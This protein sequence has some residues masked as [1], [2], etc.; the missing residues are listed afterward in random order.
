VLARDARAD[1]TFVYAVKS[2]G[3]Y[4]RPSCPSR[5]PGRA[6]AVFFKRTEDARKAGFRACRRCHPDQPGRSDER[7]FVDRVRRR[8]EEMV[9]GGGTPTLAALSAETGLSPFHLQRRFKSL[10]GV[11]PKR[12]AQ[13]LRLEKF[14]S[15]LGKGSDVTGALYEAGYGSSSRLYEN[16]G[17]RMGM[18]PAAY[19]RGGQNMD[20]R[21]DVM[22]TEK[23]R[24]LVAATPRGVCAVDV[25][26]TDAQLEERLRRC[27][28]RARVRRERGCFSRE[29]AAVSGLLS[30]R[31]EKV[32]L[33]LDLQGTAFQCRV[34]A[35]LS[36]I[37][38]G[39]TRT[40]T[41]VA[42]ALG[43]EKAARAVANACAG[44]RVP[45]VIPCHRVIRKGGELGG[46]R[47]GLDRKKAL[48][49]AEASGRGG[50]K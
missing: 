49:A 3:I 8:I 18:T 50:V 33:P 12:Y 26:A 38:Y 1:N 48:L 41:D 24:L 11:T 16:I 7:R 32:S 21:Y 19:G 28:P 22:S 31:P 20:I 36:R 30:G 6:Q 47:L 5:R 42:Q 15:R 29:L 4:C 13:W 23:G 46:Y 40:Y 34:W 17:G 25:A 45:L 39:K 43:E 35:E 10:L 9:N 14:K 2:T 37:P 27:Y 44:N